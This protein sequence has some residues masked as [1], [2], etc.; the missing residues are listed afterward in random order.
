MDV[1]RDNESKVG[2][3]DWWGQIGAPAGALTKRQ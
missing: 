2:R 3:A 1:G